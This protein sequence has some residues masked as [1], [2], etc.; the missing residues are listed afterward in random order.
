MTLF[1]LFFSLNSQHKKN[2][3]EL[4]AARDGKLH[5]ICVRW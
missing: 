1:Q 4:L 3:P 5:E 2:H